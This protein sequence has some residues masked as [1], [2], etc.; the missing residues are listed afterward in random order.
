MGILDAAMLAT[1][2][3]L[4]LIGKLQ[5]GALANKD[6]DEVAAFEEKVKSSTK[7]ERASVCVRE[8]DRETE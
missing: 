4:A 8:R 7:K 1:Q 2:D 5:T 6:K 3:L